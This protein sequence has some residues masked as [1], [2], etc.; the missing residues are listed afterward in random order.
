MF[1]GESISVKST[2]V[3]NYD[4]LL[5]EYSEHPKMTKIIGWSNPLPAGLGCTASELAQIPVII[6]PPKACSNYYQY[7]K[8][9]DNTLMCGF[10]QKGNQGIKAVII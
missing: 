2:Y 5:H 9:D 6:L 1:Q 7:G 10:L 8:F 4:P 3:R